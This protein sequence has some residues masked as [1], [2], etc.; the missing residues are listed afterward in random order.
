MVEC[1]WESMESQWLDKLSDVTAQLRR[2]LKRNCGVRIGESTVVSSKMHTYEPAWP[3]YIQVLQN[4][5]AGQAFYGRKIAGQVIHL[6]IFHQ[7]GLVDHRRVAKAVK[8]AIEIYNMH[9][10]LR[11]ISFSFSRDNEINSHYVDVQT[12][13]GG[14]RITGDLGRGTKLSLR[15]AHENH[16]HIAAKISLDQIDCVFYIVREVEQVIIDASLELRQNEKILHTKGSGGYQDMSPY[17]DPQTDSFLQERS[18]NN[19]P[20]AVKQH[21]LRQDAIEGSELF[22]NNKEFSE[23]LDQVNKGINQNKLVNDLESK[24][25]N[26]GTIDKLNAMGIISQEH[27]KVELTEYGKELRQ[28]LAINFQ[29]LQAYMRRRIRLL[30]PSGSGKVESSYSKKTGSQGVGRHIIMPWKDGGSGELAITETINAAAARAVGNKESFSVDYTDIQKAI[31]QHRT[32]HDICLVVDASAS[33]VGL[34]IRAAKFLARH[35]LLTSN[36]RVCVIIFQDNKAIVQVPL[37]K[38]YHQAEEYLSNLVPLGST[39]LAL[40][41]RTGAAYLKES[42]AVNPLMLLITDGIPTLAE[43]SR[44]PFADAIEAARELHSQKIHFTCIGLQPHSGYLQL[45]AEAAKGK[46]YIVEELE[47]QALVN[48]AWAERQQ[49]YN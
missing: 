10:A 31:K 9:S 7:V 43:K 49:L 19:L 38:C 6:D 14:G 28:Y 18:G 40:G 29:E 46:S 33:M 12:G 27:G 45:L 22:E 39:P 2:Q 41:I 42:R 13:T 21:Q 24:G 37:T 47:Q 35:L 15:R 1:G 48:V 34:R 32:K 30:K 23:F 20:Q 17:C 44:D 11:K 4:V 26:R 8:R 5:D 16:V 25:N 3:Q 36:D